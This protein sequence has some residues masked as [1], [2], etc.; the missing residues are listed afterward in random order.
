MDKFF[1]VRKCERCGGALEGGRTMS[2]F[3]T[4]CICMECA[5]KERKRPDYRE[6]VKAE[7]KAVEQG[8]RNFKGIGLK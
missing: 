1:K 6:A 4:Q 5:E 7:R 3:N 8:N 2:M